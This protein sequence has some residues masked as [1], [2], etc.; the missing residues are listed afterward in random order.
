MIANVAS[1]VEIAVAAMRCSQDLTPFDHNKIV[2]FFRKM[3]I[4]FLGWGY[5]M[6]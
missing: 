3:G 6:P 1:K 2:E 5:Q 4:L